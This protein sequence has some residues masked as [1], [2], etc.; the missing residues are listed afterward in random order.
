[1]ADAALI[2]ANYPYGDEDLSLGTP[3]PNHPSDEDQSLG[4]PV[5]FEQPGAKKMQ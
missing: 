1:L 3:V 4:T 2:L 5:S